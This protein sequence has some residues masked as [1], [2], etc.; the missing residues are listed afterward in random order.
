MP[1]VQSR[2]VRFFQLGPYLD[3][4]KVEDITTAVRSAWELLGDTNQAQMK[5]HKETKMLIAVGETNQLNTIQA[6]LRELDPTPAA[7][8]PMGMNAEMM[9]RYGLTPP[10]AAPQKAAPKPAPESQ[11][12]PQ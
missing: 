12:E 7:P 2:T 11:P 4:Y 5:F 10:P 9:K 8:K 1:A 6:V 3:K